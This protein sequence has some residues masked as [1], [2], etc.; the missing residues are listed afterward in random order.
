MYVNASIFWSATS[1]HIY[2]SEG[3][4]KYWVEKKQTL[5]SSTRFIIREWKIIIQIYDKNNR[6]C[7]N[8]IQN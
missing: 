4:V 5:S 7:D 6:K 1:L 2:N 3:V 8:L